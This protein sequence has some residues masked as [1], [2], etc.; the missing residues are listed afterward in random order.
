MVY[1]YRAYH[2]LFVDDEP[3]AVKYFE[4]AFGDTFTIL[5]A[6]TA[7]KAWQ[8]IQTHAEQIAVVISDQRM[9]GRSGT[10]LLAEIQQNHPAIVRIL[11]TAYA[12]LASAVEAVNLGGVFAYVNK[13][14]E[15]D[16]LTGTLKRAIEFFLVSRQ[17]DRLL[18]EKL[19]ALQRILVMDRVR[20]LA[21][22]ATSLS[23]QL[24]NTGAAL[25]NYVRQADLGQQVRERAESLLTLDLMIAT[26]QECKHLIRA[27]RRILAELAPLSTAAEM[28]VDLPELVSDYVHAQGPTKKE[29]GISLRGEAGPAVPRITAD[30]TLLT[31]LISVL[32]ERIGDMD[33]EDHVV[34]I[35]TEA[36]AA[37]EIRLQITADSPPWENGQVRSLYSALVPFR[38]WPMGPDMDLLAAFF[39][40]GH[41]GGTVQVVNRPPLGPGF[42]V[43]L[44]CNAAVRPTVSGEEDWLDE[45]FGSL[46]LWRTEGSLQ[47]DREAFG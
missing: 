40:A 21:T 30:R 34:R 31:R 43:Q 47:D 11:T 15:L 7:E 4:E 2:V 19:E 38:E 13:P 25:V 41:Y 18:Q 17:R 35:A 8:L 26:R 44:A 5:T 9:P 24:R 45:V 46:E 32:V 33:G 22:L 23:P 28:P 12:D 10:A 1:D 42:E 14:W 6:Q 3:Q 16:D 36:V 37:D 27:L 20:G 29:V 39:I